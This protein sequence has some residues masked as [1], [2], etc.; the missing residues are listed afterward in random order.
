MPYK[1]PEKSRLYQRQYKRVKRAA[2]KMSNPACPTLSI[3][4]SARQTSGQNMRRKS[5]VC[6]RV[7]YLRLPGIGFRDGF[8]FTDDPEEQARIESDPLYGVD[9]FSWH[10]QP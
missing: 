10:L 6:P 8:Y 7:Q 5:Y 4:R 3:P 9:I 1:D 2:A